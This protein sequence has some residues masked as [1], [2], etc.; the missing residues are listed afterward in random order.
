MKNMKSVFP[1][2][3]GF[4]L[5]SCAAFAQPIFICTPVITTPSPLPSGATSTPYSLTLA[6]FQYCPGVTWSITSG[7]LPA[8]LVMSSAGVIAGTPTTVETSTFGVTVLDSVSD[9][10]NQTYSLTITLGPLLIATPPTLPPG[11]VGTAYSQTLAATGGIAPY[12]WAVAS[13]TLPVGLVLST[14]GVISGTPTTAASSTFSATVYDSN[15][16]SASQPFTLSVSPAL[17]II[18]S[19]STLPSGV[20]GTAY[21]QTLAATGGVPPYSWAITA[22]TLPSGIA[23]STSTGVLAGTPTTPGTSSFSVNVYDSSLHYASQTFTLTIGAAPIAVATPASLPSGSTGTAYS[24]TL[25][26]TGGV[27]PYT[28]SII[29]GALPSG[30]TLSSAGVI[31]GTPTVIGNYAF[32][33]QAQD[34]SSATASQSF[35]LTVTAPGALPR[36]GIISQLSAGAGWVTTIWLINRSAAPLKPISFFTATTAAR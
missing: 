22:G 12:S 30:L 5:M 28:W 21:S 27:P 6:G 35:S 10:A 29:S 19:P 23:F 36:A 34:S 3:I 26:A 24:Q 7:A 18:T 33:A 16:H 8:G 20:T 2:V 4:L 31:A 32:A 1:V 17:L 15:S 11:V 13:G 25:A 9:I 14:G